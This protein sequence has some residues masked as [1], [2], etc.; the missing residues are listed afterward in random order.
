MVVGYAVYYPFARLIERGVV[1]DDVRGLSAELEREPLARSREGLLDSLPHLGR[2]GERD[3]VH[4]G[5]RHELGARAAVAGDDVH[6][7]R[8]QLGLPDHVA[9]QER[10]Q[11]CG[12][13]G[14]EHDSITCRQRGRDL[15]REHE[16][17]EVPRDDLTGHAEG[18]RRAMREGVLE[19]VRPPRVIE[20]VRRSERKIDVA[21]FADRLAPVHRFEYSELTRALLKDARDPEEVL[22]A[23][24]GTDA[25]PAFGI[26]RA[27]G[28][29]RPVDIRLA[30]LRDL[31]E[32][33]LTRGI[34]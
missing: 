24:A 27:R 5:V 29:Y 33:R 28:F 32:G 22:G 26:R 18:P 9:G 12:L 13:R 1:E 19:L 16:Q 21:R 7:A 31:G 10:R 20:E 34:D 8:R 6:D 23:L 2:A 4:V 14:F 25:R 3:L 17:R 15:P 30:G 11:R